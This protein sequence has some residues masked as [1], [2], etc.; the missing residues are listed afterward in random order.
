M[1]V[2][3]IVHVHSHPVR[4]PCTK[5]WTPCGRDDRW[6]NFAVVKEQTLSSCECRDNTVRDSVRDPVLPGVASCTR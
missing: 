5:C 6:T 2:V 3:D 1:I 4:V